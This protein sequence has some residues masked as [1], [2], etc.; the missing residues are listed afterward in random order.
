MR[1][2]SIAFKDLQIFFKDRGAVFFLFLVPLFFVIAYSGVASAF[3]EEAEDVKIAL[4]VVDLDGGEASAALLSGLNAAGGVETVQYDEAEAQT[5]LE[6]EQIA[7]L[8]TIPADF[9]AN[10]ARSVPVTLKLV[11][12]PSANAR[13]TEVVRLVVEGVARDLTLQNQIFTSLQQMGEMQAN[14]PAAFREAF[15]TERLQAQ[16]QSQFENSR[17]RPLVTVVQ[18]VPAVEEEREETPNLGLLAVPGF[19]VLFVFLMAQTTARSIYD[20]RKVGSF[21]RLMAAPLSKATLL[22]G[23]ILPNFLTALIQIVVIFGFGAYGLKLMDFT[24]VPLGKDPLALALVAIVVALCSSSLGVVIA[25]IA[26]TESQIGGISSLLLWG[27][28]A[29][30][31]SIIPLF[32]LETFLGPLPKIVPHYWANKAFENVMIRGLGLVDVLPQIGVLL[33]FTLLFLAIGVW[34]FDFE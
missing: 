32:A 14:A 12:I 27:M 31:G 13:Q 19:A 4:P 33:G 28:G 29:I 26:R 7:R 21:R 1:A 11:N 3:G 24:P 22:T 8:L 6:N 10:L 15:S 16:A 20:E 18:T 17:G 9:G 2:L 23:K 5:L 25:A 34:R 30:G